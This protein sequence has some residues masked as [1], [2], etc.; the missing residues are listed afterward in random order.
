M[1]CAAALV[2]RSAECGTGRQ[3]RDVGSSDAARPWMWP[4]W[5][6]LGDAEAERGEGR[7]D[8]PARAWATACLDAGSAPCLFARARLWAAATCWSRVQGKDGLK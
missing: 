5:T 7:V 2:V 6:G 3:R 8:G 4:D 1:R